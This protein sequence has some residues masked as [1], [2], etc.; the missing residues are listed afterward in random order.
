MWP[1]KKNGW[2][3]IQATGKFSGII[4]NFL[5]SAIIFTVKKMPHSVCSTCLLSKYLRHELSLNHIIFWVPHI[6]LFFAKVWYTYFKIFCNQKKPY[7]TAPRSRKNDIS[8]IKKHFCRYIHCTVDAY[9]VQHTCLSL[10]KD[11]AVRGF[12]ALSGQ[13][14]QAGSL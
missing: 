9:H 13:P 10:C 8:S 11:K 7:D 3:L 4:L 1:S 14:F 5:G 12:S 6:G 2:G